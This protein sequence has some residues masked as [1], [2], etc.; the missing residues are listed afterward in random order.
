MPQKAWLPFPTVAG[1]PLVEGSVLFHCYREGTVGYAEAPEEE[2]RAA[3]LD[4]TQHT[5]WHRHISKG[6]ANFLMSLLTL[7]KEQRWEKSCPA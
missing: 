5:N 2:D 4:V 3:I 7:H 1:T 6:A